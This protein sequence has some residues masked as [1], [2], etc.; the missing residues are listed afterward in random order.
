MASHELPVFRMK[1]AM[2]DSEIPPWIA[3]SDKV[4][5]IYDEEGFTTVYSPKALLKILGRAEFDRLAKRVKEPEK[6]RRTKKP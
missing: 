6:V 4:E 5:R 1:L 2:L 3:A